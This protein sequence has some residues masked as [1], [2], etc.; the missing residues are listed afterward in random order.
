MFAEPNARFCQVA[1]VTNRLEEA[2]AMFGREYGCPG[3]YSFGNTDG[4]VVPSDGAELK[5]ALAEVGGVQIELI[6]PIG[7]T[8]PL[9]SDVLPG[10]PE[11]AVRFHHTAIQVEG[12]MQDWERHLAALD[13]ARHPIVVRGGLGEVMRYVYTDERRLVGHYVEH[14]WMAPELIRQMATLVPRYPA[15]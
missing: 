1:Y 7:N 11:L 2:M 15:R 4:G 13:T 5:I 8:A 9:Y 3:F 14:V 10:G 6:E 12:T